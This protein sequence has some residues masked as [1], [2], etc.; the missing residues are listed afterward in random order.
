MLAAPPSRD[1]AAPLPQ[2]MPPLVVSARTEASLRELVR[3]WCGA[4]AGTPAE[5]APVLL[6]AAAPKSRPPRAPACRAGEG[7]G[8]NRGNARR[9]SRR[10]PDTGVITE[11]GVREDKLAFVFSGNGAQFPGMGRDALRTNA[12]FRAAIEEVDEA[13]PAGTRLVRNRASRE[14]GRQ[15]QAGARRHRATASFRRPGRNR[16]GAGGDWY[17]RRRPFWAQCR[18]DRRSLECRRPFARR[19]RAASSSCAAVISSKPRAWA[20]WRRSR[21]PHDAARAI[22]AELESTAEIAAVNAARSVTISGSTEEIGRLEAELEHREIGFRSLDLGLRLPL[23]SDGPVPRGSLGG[24][25]RPR[26]APARGTCS[27]RQ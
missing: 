25:C 22:L 11:T 27:Y 1:I 5:R 13:A 18:R 16:S 15:R 19:C 10:R 2:S 14:R 4:L 7:S 3:S 26:F 23:A 9:L 17:P 20:G 12:V 21:S 24:S 6:R 8:D